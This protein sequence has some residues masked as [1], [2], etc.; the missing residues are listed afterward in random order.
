MN[1]KLHI[2]PITQSEA[3]LFVSRFHR[4]HKPPVGSIFQIACSVNAKI[5]GVIIAGRP[6]ARHLDNGFCLEV[7]RLATNGTKNA[8]SILYA[9]AW[10]A[11]K[12]LGYTRLI[13]YILSSEH[14][15][16]LRA[17][18]WI[19]LGVRG[20]RSWNCQSRPR[21]DKHPTQRKILFE[22]P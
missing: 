11:A 20:G 1:D 12:S 18:G 13:T 3:K 5:V 21:V 17:S 4:H 10:R 6:I 22:A 14:G 19:E 15:T 7:T 2:V 9:A 8:C 16:S